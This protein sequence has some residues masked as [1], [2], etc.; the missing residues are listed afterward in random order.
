MSKLQAGKHLC[1]I[2]SYGLLIEKTD[3]VWVEFEDANQ[4]AITWFGYLTEKAAPFTVDKL[5]KIFGLMAGPAEINSCLERIGVD[6]IDSGLLNTEKEYEVVVE[7]ETYDGKT[8]QKVKYVNDPSAPSKFGKIAAEQIKGKFDHLN[9]AGHVA[10]MKIPKP[11]APKPNGQA[12]TP[13]HTSD[14]PF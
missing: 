13:V 10:S 14:I 3:T 9:L 1:K 4:N 5:I 7:D 11:A 8:R 6:G 2:T 12:A